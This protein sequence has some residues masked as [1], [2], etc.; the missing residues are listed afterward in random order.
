MFEQG[1]KIQ[2]TTVGQVLSE[3]FQNTVQEGKTYCI[4]NFE[5]I[6]NAKDYK[7]TPHPF[8]ILFSGSTHVKDCHAEITVGRF[9]FMPLGEIVKAEESCY[10]S[11]KKPMLQYIC[12]MLH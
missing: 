12:L 2:A 1:T 4:S 8:R 11:N 3:K 6:D 7:A 10:K 5:V 9:Q